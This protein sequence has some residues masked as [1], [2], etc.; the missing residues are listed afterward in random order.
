MAAELGQPTPVLE[1]V[2]ATNAG[3]PEEMV[4]LAEARL[5]TLEGLRAAVLGIAFKPDTD[6]VRESPAIPIVKRLLASG[7]RVVVHDPVVT[8]L[9]DEICTPDVTLTNELGDALAGTHVAL[10]VT[11]WSVYQNLP[12]ILA[13]LTDVPLLVDG[14]R[15]LDRRSVLRYAGIGCS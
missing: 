8:K 5:G 15:M 2:V 14:R 13:E 6:D 3:R 1:A 9:P 12:A 11:R 10:L 7:A 4:R